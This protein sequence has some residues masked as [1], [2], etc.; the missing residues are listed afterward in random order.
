MAIVILK[1][2]L[3]FL[4]ILKPIK[5][6]FFKAAFIGFFIDLELSKSF[7]IFRQRAHACCVCRLR[8]AMILTEFFHAAG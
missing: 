3:L 8:N 2:E 7:W 6:A 4:S 1:H 5:A